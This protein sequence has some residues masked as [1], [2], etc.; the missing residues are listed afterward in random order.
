MMVPNSPTTQTWSGSAYEIAY[1][2]TS[3]GSTP[4]SSALAG[5][6]TSGPTRTTVQVRPPSS[7][8]IMVPKS[9][10]PWP[11]AGVANWRLKRWRDEPVFAS[12]QVAPP[13]LVP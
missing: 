12:L 13:S 7:V 5:S 1:R 8:W 4:V 3:P 10:A 9:P 11:R 2:F 6:S